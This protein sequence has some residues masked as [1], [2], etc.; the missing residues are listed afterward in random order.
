M[1]N[2]KENTEKRTLE[3]W[4]GSADEFF[5]KKERE[6]FLWYCENERFISR[7][8]MV[9]KKHFRGLMAGVGY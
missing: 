9:T 1:K 3:S 8:A 5:D 4:V 7:S 2:K 6:Q